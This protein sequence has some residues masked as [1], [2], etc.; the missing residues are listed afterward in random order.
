M[1]EILRTCARRSLLVGLP[2]LL[3]PLG[4]FAAD[5]GT[6]VG[7]GAKAWAENC[8]RCHNIREP[9]E[10][11]DDLWRPIVYHMRVRGGLT[12][13]EARDVLKFL[14]SANN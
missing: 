10:F 2:V 4:A 8:S 12:G 14:Q 5:E 9:N 11:R 13:Q 3:L 7:R 1:K 6:D